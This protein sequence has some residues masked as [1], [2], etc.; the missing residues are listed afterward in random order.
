VA[1]ATVAEAEAFVGIVRAALEPRL[2]DLE[3]PSRR[4]RLTLFAS[5]EEFAEF[6]SGTLSEDL[7]HNGG[8]F[9]VRQLEIALVLTDEGATRLGMRHEVA[10]LLIARGGGQEAYSM[11]AWLTEGLATWIESLDS[12]ADPLVA[13]W[14]ADLARRQRASPPI[15]EILDTTQRS[16]T[17]SGNDATYA[18]ANLLVHFLIERFGAGFW[19]YVRDAREGDAQGRRA[20]ERQF[21]RLTDLEAGWQDYLAQ[22]R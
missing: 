6:T 19:A 11:P 16:F 20:F 1:E 2:G 21:G 9:D 10:H 18:H 22:L 14:V 4:I 3:P 13:F 12:G 15:G 5:H 8:Y 17:E 7:S